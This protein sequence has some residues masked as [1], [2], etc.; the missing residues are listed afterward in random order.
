MI[1]HTDLKLNKE[2][3]TWVKVWFSRGEWCLL[4][5]RPPPPLAFPSLSTL[6]DLYSFHDD[7]CV[8]PWF[9]FSHLTELPLYSLFSDEDQFHWR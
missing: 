2:N 9:I 4:L 8:C 5:T 6:F 7:T 3:F 1:H